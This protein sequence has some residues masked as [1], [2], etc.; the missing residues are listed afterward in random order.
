MIKYFFW[1]IHTDGQQ[2]HEKMLSI[3][4]HQG[5]A[6]QMKYHFTPVRMAIIRKPRN[7]YCWWGSDEKGILVQCWWEFKLIQPLWNIL[8]RS[9]KK[10]KIV[11][12]YHPAIPLAFLREKKRYTHPN[13][14]SRIIY[15]NQ[16]I[17]SFLPCFLSIIM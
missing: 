11:L 17:S 4:N 14:H 9:L 5:N 10:L 2:A 16:D 15:N 1:R 8:W 12:L 7:S 13:I 3:T 6:N